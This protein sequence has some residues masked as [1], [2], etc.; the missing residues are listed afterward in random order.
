MTLK[1][2]YGKEFFEEFTTATNRSRG[3]TEELFHLVGEDLSK[4][5]EL[6]EKLSNN[7]VGWVPG[8]KSD[9]ALVMS[10]PNS[11]KVLDLSLF[12]NL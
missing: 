9:V 8:D 6:E 4:L 3:Q 5:V 1:D 11:L 2:K 12:K 7:F 10:M